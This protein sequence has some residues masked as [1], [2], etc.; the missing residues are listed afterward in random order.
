FRLA[1]GFDTLLQ[2]DDCGHRIQTLH[3]ALKARHFFFDQSFC[4]CR[5]PTTVAHVRF[6]YLLK[7]VDVINKDSFD[8]AHLCIH[9]AWNSNVDEEHWAILTPM[10]EHLAVLAPEDGVRSAGGCDHD[11]GLIGCAIE[12]IKKDRAA[13]DS[14]RHPQC[15]FVRTIGN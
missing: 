13:P 12:L 14:L 7:V 11:V 10:H 3:A 8:L 5:L 15:P 1:N 6:D 2:R 9:V 4:P